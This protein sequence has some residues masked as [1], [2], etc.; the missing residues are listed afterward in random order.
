MDVPLLALGASSGG[1][2]WDEFF[3]AA[4]QRGIFDPPWFG[5][6]LCV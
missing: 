1:D 3:L 5:E 4:L 6:E 2:T